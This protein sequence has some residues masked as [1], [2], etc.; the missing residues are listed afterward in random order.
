METNLSVT[1]S[2]VD[3][4]GQD[5]A[6]LSACE[7]GLGSVLHGLHVPLSGYFL[8][9]NQIFLLSRSLFTIRDPR[10]PLVI[11]TTAAV[12]KALSPA[13]KKLTP[14]LAISAQGGLFTLGP[15]VFGPSILGAASGAILASVWSF[16]QPALLAYLIFGSALVKAI[17]S[18][19]AKIQD[20]L[21]FV[22]IDATQILW[23]ALALIGLKAIL[24][25][26]CAALA[27][28]LP[29]SHFTL[30]QKRLL[31]AAAKSPK[32]EVARTEGSSLSTRAKLAARDLMSP[33]FVIS[34]ILT[35]TFFIYADA[36]ASQLIWVI[37]RPVAVGFCLFLV[38]RSIP[39]DWLESRWPTVAVALRKM[40][41][42]LG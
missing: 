32:L 15:L 37:L 5:A 12:L 35:L 33:L 40:R 42:L 14:M 10:A 17:E 28:K 1:A 24:A 26:G 41:N 36:S 18:F 30:W 6:V 2:K 11:S 25:V 39:L 4:L 20:S 38:V 16:L 34:M 21:T 13:G 9:L 27:W 8:S 31:A 19:F 22:E 29:D 23:I 7:V 3:V